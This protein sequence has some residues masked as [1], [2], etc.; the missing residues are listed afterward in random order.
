MKKIRFLSQDLDNVYEDEELSESVEN[1]VFNEENKLSQELDNKKVSKT[2]SFSELKVY[3]NSKAVALEYGCSIN[4]EVTNVGD[5][6]GVFNTRDKIPPVKSTHIKSKSI[7]NL[8]SV[9]MDK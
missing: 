5:N 3:E 2:M 8:H 1:V 4:S 6:I 7:S 9:I